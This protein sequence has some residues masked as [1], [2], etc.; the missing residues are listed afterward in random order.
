MRHFPS[1]KFDPKPLTKT[2][3]FD[4]LTRE[5]TKGAKLWPGRV[6]HD[7]AYIPEVKKVGIN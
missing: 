2:E 4:P 5:W 3:W 6:F 1:A 7:M